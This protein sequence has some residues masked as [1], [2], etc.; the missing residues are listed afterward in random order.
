MSEHRTTV[1]SV[2]AL[3]IA[4]LS[5]T[6]FGEAARKAILPPNS[7]GTPQLRAGAVTAPKIRNGTVAGSDLA[8]R[9]IIN[10]HIKPGSLLA[11]SFAPGQ[12]GVGLSEL[13]IVT[14]PTPID[15]SP[16]KVLVIN[17]PV[18]K[19]VIGGG[20][21]VSEKHFTIGLRQS[22]PWDEDSWYVTAARF[23]EPPP[24]GGATFWGLTGY[25]ICAKAS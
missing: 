19:K 10:G 13:E 2:M 14:S 1:L 23:L 7:V 9:T 12:L 5:W 11:S 21:G 4:V 6:P 18:G 24:E 20:A 8:R 16:T 17:C 15:P 25:A 22:R 3:V